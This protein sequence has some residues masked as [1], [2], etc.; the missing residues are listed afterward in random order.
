[1]PEDLLSHLNP[2]QKAELGRKVNRLCE[3]NRKDFDPSHLQDARDIAEALAP[4][5]QSKTEGIRVDRTTNGSLRV[6]MRLGER[7]GPQ[8]QAQL[9]LYSIQ[10]DQDFLPP[11]TVYSFNREL[12]VN[13]AHRGFFDAEPPATEIRVSRFSGEVVSVRRIHQLGISIEGKNGSG[14]VSFTAGRRL[15]GRRI[16]G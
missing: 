9:G 8:S 1:M 14:A 4:L 7:Q 12:D 16:L 10:M 13:S 15:G 11:R 6:R 5:A 2:L 3:V